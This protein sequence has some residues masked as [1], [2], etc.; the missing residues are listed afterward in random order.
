MGDFIQPQPYQP[1]IAV[2]PYISAG[3]G[4]LG[5]NQI[6]NKA[7][8]IANAVGIPLSSLWT[9]KY[10]TTADAANIKLSQEQIKSGKYPNPEYILGSTFGLSIADKWC[11]LSYGESSILLEIAIITCTKPIE[12]NIVPVMGLQDSSVKEQIY[13]ADTQISIVGAFYSD[14]D[15]VTPYTEAKILKAIVESPYIKISCPYLTNVHKIDRMICTN[16]ELKPS[17]EFTNC[18]TFSLDCLSDKPIDIIFG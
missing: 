1:P 14:V 8:Y 11:E 7:A 6:T 15:Y 5:S 13:R 17:E 9:Y 12:Y 3:V 18:I 10:P 4:T 2:Q 16:Y